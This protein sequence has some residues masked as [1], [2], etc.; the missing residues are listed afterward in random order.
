MAPIRAFEFYSGIGGAVP[1]LHERMACRQQHVGSKRLMIT[2]ATL[3]TR[4]STCSGMHCALKAAF[5]GATVAR[6]FDISPTA[7]DAYEFVF[8]TRPWQVG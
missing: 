6:A 5:P 2:D 4:S 7:N 1:H 8:G 3:M